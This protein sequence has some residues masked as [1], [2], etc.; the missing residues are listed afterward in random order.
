MS[1]T[2]LRKMQIIF[3]RLKFSAHARKV[4]ICSL[5]K[6]IENQQYIVYQYLFVSNRLYYQ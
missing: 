5:F 6:I 3:Q 1:L 4:H 2:L